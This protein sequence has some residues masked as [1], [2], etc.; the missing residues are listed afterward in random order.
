M[1][2]GN[3]DLSGQMIG[4][5]RYEVTRRLDKGSMGYVYLAWDRSLEAHVVVKV[6]KVARL[7]DPEFRMRFERES[8]YLV[9]MSH[10]H[11]IRIIDVGTQDSVPYYVMQYVQGGSLR[12][13][14]FDE[15]N[16]IKPMPL[17]TLSLWLLQVAKALDFVNSQSMIHR[18]VK[19]ANILFD[20]YNNP[21]LS[22]FGLSKLQ[23]ASPEETSS[24]MTAAGAIVGTPN[25]VAPEIVL[26]RAYNGSA[27]QYSLAISV[28]EVLTGRAPLEGPTASATMVNQ[29]SKTA[30]LLTEMIMGCPLHVA[31]AV[32]KALNKEP[33]RRFANCVDFANAVL[34]P[35]KSNRESNSNLNTVSESAKSSLKG[36]SNS[37]ISSPP[38][39]SKWVIAKV[40]RGA[41]GKIPCPSCQKILLVSA[42]HARK[43][44]T[45]KHC[46]AKLAV[47][48]NLM[49]LA[50]LVRN[51]SYKSGV[52]D[53]KSG[54]QDE[55]SQV[56]GQE[57]FGMK[58]SARQA[59]YGALC[60]V[61]IIMIISLY[62]GYRYAKDEQQEKES[63]IVKKEQL[64]N[65]KSD[66]LLS[67]MVAT[68]QANKNVII[69][70]SEEDKVWLNELI[71]LFQTTSSSQPEKFDILSGNSKQ[72]A[73]YSS[74]P[75]SA[76]TL[77]D[78]WIPDSQLDVYLINN[79]LKDKLSM[80]SQ[81]DIMHS[82]FVCLMPEDR[83]RLLNQNSDTI[84]LQKLAE[85]VV[86]ERG[87]S[88]FSSTNDW[89]P[90]K[91]A[92][93]A[94]QSHGP[95][96]IPLIVLAWQFQT[97]ISDT[98]SI[99]DV[100]K[101]EFRELVIK[102]SRQQVV[103]ISTGT[104]SFIPLVQEL[105]ISK[106]SKADAIILPE[107][108]ALRSINDLK[109]VWGSVR[110]MYI[111]PSIELKK[112]II[113]CNSKDKDNNK[114]KDKDNNKSMQ[115]AGIAGFGK[116]EQFIDSVT[117]MGFRPININ[118]NKITEIAPLF[119]EH[120]SVGVQDDIADYNKLKT[121]SLEVLEELAK[122]VK[123]LAQ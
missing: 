65:N 18:D 83:A 13:R 60:M 87:W 113:S 84:S 25:Y 24:H 14:M 23:Q 103:N 47:G 89:G 26:G 5:D 108:I 2:V 86:D 10:P 33:E 116:I 38:Q 118:K 80:Q 15:N 54:S 112:S 110:L 39:V 85:A 71:S 30:P 34:N 46:Q 49:E 67:Q 123:E 45:C 88:A 37:T 106:G 9:K 79:I 117:K 41:K 50:Q 61:G 82:P 78:G 1:S 122:L 62:M 104:N 36:S 11:I 91:L 109:S 66:N 4:N 101:E 7:E 92:M 22:D 120:Q 95:E 48:E 53:S 90:V 105:I 44:A 96:F 40:S 17:S 100:R 35:A 28:Y 68:P 119:K 56:L 98:L 16:R 59:I 27:D 32:A 114:F 111:S 76:E 99:E 55:F 31:H 43:K 51:A 21:Y 70:S 20:E 29:T 77:P 42:E 97:N 8:K 93:P 6:P 58:L 12:D 75:S 107:Y 63:K 73:K 57:V 64:E 52:M 121:P 74:S 19:P 102:L 3:T 115:I 69:M 72:F 81:F 94:F